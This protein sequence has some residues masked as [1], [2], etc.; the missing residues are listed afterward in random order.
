MEVVQSAFNGGLNTIGLDTKIQ[1]NAYV[2]AI[3]ARPRFSY[4]KPINKHKLIDKPYGGVKVQ[5][6]IGVG[7]VLFVFIDGQAYLRVEGQD[8]WSIVPFFSLSPNADKFWA[9]AVP[10][11]SMNY[12]RKLD[13]SQNAK[14]EIIVVPDFKVAGTPSCIVVQD[15]INQPQI[16]EIQVDTQN[17]TSTFIARDAKT[18]NEWSNTSIGDNSREYVPIGKQM[19]YVNDILFIVSR[20]AKTVYRSVTGRPLDFVISVDIYGNKAPLEADGGASRLSFAFDY[21]NITGIFPVN[22][23]NSFAYATARNVRIITIDYTRMLFSEPTFYV[24]AQ[25]EA[26]VVNEN[27]FIDILGDY[28]FIDKEGII[29]FNAVEQLQS[30]GRNSVFSLNVSKVLEGKKQFRSCCFHVDNY[31]IFNVDSVWGNVMLVYDMLLE[32]W[33]SVDITDVIRIKDVAYT[34][35]TEQSKVYCVTRYNEIFELFGKT[36]EVYLCQIRTKAHIPEQSNIEQKSAFFRPVFV[37]GA[38][39]AQATVIEFVDD[40]IS[41][42]IDQDLNY[43]ISSIEYPV[44]PP[45]IPHTIKQIDNPQYTLTGGLTGKKIHFIVQWQSSARLFEYQFRSTEQQKNT[46]VVQG[47]SYL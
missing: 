47:N 42:R 2:W 18:Y 21:D 23:P 9:C 34:E 39:N 15:G 20:D 29:S 19:L 43:S 16:I 4:V 32:N 30:N 37:G 17:N 35:T 11:S 24:S 40:V 14:D 33:V 28:A 45:V 8:E 12:A 22:I 36:D 46:S 7:D 26:G 10:A 38:T 3:N 1:D 25:I 13:A 31:A 6:C 41:Q 5:G 44:R 27:S